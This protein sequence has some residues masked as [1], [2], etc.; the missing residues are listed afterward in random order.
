MFMISAEDRKEM[1][2]SMQGLVDYQ[3]Q[4]FGEQT[5]LTPDFFYVS[6]KG[7]TSDVQDYIISLFKEKFR[8]YPSADTCIYDPNFFGTFLD[9]L[10]D[11]WFVL[12]RNGDDTWTLYIP[13][14]SK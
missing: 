1:T 12:E 13:T 10:G 14:N 7:S 9:L 5:Y 4:T 3:V 8:D 6:Y 11:L 2:R